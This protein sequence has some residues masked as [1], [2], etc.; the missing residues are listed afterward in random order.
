LKTATLSEIK[1]ELSQLSATEMKELCLRLAKFKKENKELIT[2]ILFE[3]GN[4]LAYEQSIKQLIDGHFEA[5]DLTNNLYLI[6]KSLRKILRITAKFIKY[7]NDEKLEVRLLLYFCTKIKNSGIPIEKST[8]ISNLFIT[9]T[10]KIERLI[11]LLHE[12][13]QFD[14]INQFNEINF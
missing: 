7:S 6:K 10:K 9:Q 1:T 13:L 5:I 4:E 8:A 2:F 14:Y 3:Q 11:P 12:D